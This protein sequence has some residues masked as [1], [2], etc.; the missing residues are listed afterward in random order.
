MAAQSTSKSSISFLLPLILN[1]PQISFPVRFAR[2]EGL[3]RLKKNQGSWFKKGHFFIYTTTHHYCQVG[4]NGSISLIPA[5]LSK[6]VACSLNSH[7]PSP[8][9]CTPCPS[10]LISVDEVICRIIRNG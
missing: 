4:R 6:L 8:H 10:I 1:P 3:S 5:Y 2:G 9:P 7:G